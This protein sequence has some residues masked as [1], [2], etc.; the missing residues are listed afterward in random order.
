MNILLLGGLPEEY[1]GIPISADFRNMINVDLILKDT[2]LNEQ[3]K[4]IAALSQLYPKIP[5]N[6]NKAAEGLAWF[7]SQGDIGDSKSAGT[8]KD[9]KKAYDFEQD[10]SLIY[11]AFYSTYNINLATIDFLH[12]WEFK[13]LFEGLPE[14]TLIQRVMYWRTADVGSLPKHEKKFITKMRSRFALKGSEK[15]ITTV[16]ELNQQTQERVARRYA[17]AQAALNE[18]NKSPSEEGR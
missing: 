6:L 10:A 12:W 8:K 5:A 15:K 3:E 17:E 4:T 11:S 1:E 9:T 7:Y 16:E 18:K 13:A 14:T 2:D